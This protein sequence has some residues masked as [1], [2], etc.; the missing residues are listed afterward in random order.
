M[1]TEIEYSH[2]RP[3]WTFLNRI[4]YLDAYQTAVPED[5]KMDELVARMFQMTPAW[6]R[7]LMKVRDSV[8]ALLGLKTAKDDRPSEEQLR[9]LKV[10]DRVGL[11]QVLE[12]TPTL[13]VFGENDKHL[14]FRVSLEL[15]SQNKPSL[16]TMGTAVQYNAPM[17]KLYFAVVKPFH[18][19]VAPAMLNRLA[20][21]SR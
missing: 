4:D 20:Q 15:D 21:T 7:F 10:G 18:R 2:L 5:S 6:I 1:V 13:M 12:K 19:M 3:L 9:T 8:V 11:F 16:L 17:G 14:N